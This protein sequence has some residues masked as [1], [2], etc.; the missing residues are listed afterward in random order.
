MENEDVNANNYHEV[1]AFRNAAILL[2]HKR[3][4]LD[5]L[6]ARLCHH[7]C[8]TLLSANEH[9]LW[10]DVTIRMSPETGCLSCGIATACSAVLYKEH[11]S[12]VS[13]PG[14]YIS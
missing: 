6:H 12:G 9:Q 14:E 5:L 4:P 13:R 1:P 3:L 10:K 2:Q 7:K 8:R 11:H